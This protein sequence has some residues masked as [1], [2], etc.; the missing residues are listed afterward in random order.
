[1]QDTREVPLAV[2]C[3]G[4]VGVRDGRGSPRG[5]LVEDVGR[6]KAVL[7]RLPG[8]SPVLAVCSP[9]GRR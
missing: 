7:H 6:D 9:L 5:G 1:M 3:V 4:E 2:A 8:L